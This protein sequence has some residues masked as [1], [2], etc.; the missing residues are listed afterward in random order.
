MKPNEIKEKKLEL[1]KELD[2]YNNR[3]RFDD[4]ISFDK[5]LLLG[6]IN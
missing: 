2:K 1:Q 6:L 4:V 3:Y 5:S